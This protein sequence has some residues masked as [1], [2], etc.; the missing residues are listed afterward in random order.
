MI[1]VVLGRRCADNL[2]H[3]VDG[4]IR[5]HAAED[6]TRREQAEAR[7]NADTLVYQTEKLLSEQG[8]SVSGEEKEAVTQAVADLKS[9]LEGED[10]EAIKSATDRLASTSQTFSQK[11]YEQA[12]QQAATPGMVDL[13]NL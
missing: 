6:A 8:E 2:G 13:D 10:T 1:L 5:A 11:L 9:A 12:A 3:E 7:N 4:R